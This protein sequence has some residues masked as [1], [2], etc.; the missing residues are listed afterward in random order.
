MD[1]AST[2]RK[3]VVLLGMA[4]AA[5]AHAPYQARL[6]RYDPATG[7]RFRSVP[8]PDGVS[9]FLYFSGG[10]TRAAALSYGVLQTL[11]ESHPFAD[12]PAHSRLGPSAPSA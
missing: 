3:G 12:L 9:V 1:M 6:A 8:N 11:A 10:G 4:V 5:C 7:Y 2:F